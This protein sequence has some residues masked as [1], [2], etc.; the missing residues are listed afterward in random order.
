MPYA[1]AVYTVKKAF[2]K[3]EVM[4]S[5]EDIGFANSVISNKA[6]NLWRKLKLRNLIILEIC[7]QQVLQIHGRIR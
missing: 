1:D 7:Q 4:N 6:V 3:R 5:I 2:S